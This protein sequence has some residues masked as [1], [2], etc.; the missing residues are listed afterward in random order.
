MTT[1]TLSPVVET[2]HHTTKVL[3]NSKLQEAFTK[4]CTADQHRTFQKLM[5][6]GNLGSATALVTRVVI[7]ETLYPLLEREHILK[8]K[9]EEEFGPSIYD[10]AP[11]VVPLDTVD[12]SP[13]GQIA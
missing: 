11:E 5:D 9:E 2:T 6:E 8:A 4:I 10:L 7:D 1:H 12:N 13:R 3:P